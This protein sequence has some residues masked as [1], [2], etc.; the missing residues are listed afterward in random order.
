M[1]DEERIVSRKPR[2][3]QSRGRGL[4][5]TTGWYVCPEVGHLKP[6]AFLRLLYEHI[7]I[8]KLA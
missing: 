7:L 6:P 4:R 1:A 2:H 5:K 8:V 3:R